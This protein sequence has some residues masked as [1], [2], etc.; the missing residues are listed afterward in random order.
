MW[1]VAQ[2]HIHYL[3]LPSWAEGMAYM[4]DDEDDSYTDDY[5]TDNNPFYS[6]GGT[7]EL[8]PDTKEETTGQE[9]QEPIDVGAP[10][11]EPQPEVNFPT[12][13]NTPP[14]V[15]YVPSNGTVPRPCEKKVY[16]YNLQ[17]ERLNTSGMSNPLK[18]K[19]TNCH[20]SGCERYD[21]TFLEEKFEG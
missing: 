21:Y 8:T 3:W 4:S 20:A 10:E 5:E 11:P 2:T 1:I 14:P 15:K 17:P 19:L 6:Y 7:D 12:N 13:M 16:L 9:S 18:G